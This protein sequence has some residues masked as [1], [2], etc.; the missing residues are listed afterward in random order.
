MN[1]STPFLSIITVVF[2]N[3]AGLK[4]TY[5]SI[6]SQTS[7]DFEWLVIDGG[8]S[9]GTKEWLAGLTVPNMRFVSEKDAGLYDAMNKGL[10][11]ATGKFVWFMN[12]GDSIFSSDTVQTLIDQSADNDVLYGETMLVDENDTRLGIRSE[13]T[14]RVLPEK[15]TRFSMIMGMV[16]CHQSFIPQRSLAPAYNLNYRFSADIDWVISCLE[17]AS[18]IHNCKT[19]LS[20]YLV[21]GLSAQNQKTG[22]KERWK[23]YVAHYGFL[24]TFLAHIYIAFRYVWVFKILKRN[25]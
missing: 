23:I 10:K 5:Q 16:V 15:M 2:N 8:S 18:S 11:L 12:S 1:S 17:N 6:K 13:K 19:I 7:T 3:L 24:Y 20:N 22:W 21:G 4:H 25:Y 9:D 14:T